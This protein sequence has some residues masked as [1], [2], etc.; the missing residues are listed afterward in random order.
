MTDSSLVHAAWA[1]LSRAERDAAY[2]NTAAVPDSPSIQAA[3]EAAS[4]VYRA[5]CRSGLDI[6]Y[7][8]HERQKWD[9]FPS[10]EPSAPV[11]V[12]IHGGYWQRG[13]RDVVSVLAEGIRANGWSAAFPGYRIAPDASLTEIVADIHAA[14]DWLAASGPD[15]GIAGPI[16]V[17]GHS[18]GGHLT[19]MALS[20][21]K[22]TAALAISGVFELGPIR[23]TYLNEKLRLTDEE[24]ATLSPLRLPVVNKPLSI[25]YGT[26]ELAALVE[27]SR[28]L[29]ARR[30]AAHAPGALLP[31]PGANHF[32]IIDGLR[33]PE[34]FLI[35][36]IL[37]LAR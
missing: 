15:H 26:V 33:D 11:L 6:P 36:Q 7:G 12:F 21:P 1:R 10:A 37:D 32:D 18:A 27:D 29:H 17:A 30:A 34:G 19:A 5:R 25:T 13:S 2:N 35:R 23:D 9:L 14:L 20:H 16:I 28:A 31:I 22:V 24:V 8:S 3:R 4:A